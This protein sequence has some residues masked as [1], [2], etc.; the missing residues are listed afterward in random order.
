[1]NK[2]QTL[3]LGLAERFKIVAPG[4]KEEFLDS[5][6]LEEIPPQNPI[7]S[8]MFDVGDITA[9]FGKSK[10]F[11]SWLCAQLAICAATGSDFLN[12]K[13]QKP[14]R[15]CLFQF[16]ISSNHFKRRLQKIVRS[17]FPF[18]EPDLGLMSIRSCR[19]GGIGASEILEIAK[20]DQLE[21]I[22]VDPI[23]LLNEMT[24]ENSA[25]AVKN[26]LKIFG[27]IG[28]LGCAVCYTH[29]DR[30]GST[31]SD[32][33][34]RGSGSGVHARFYDAGIF[35]DAHAE[36]PDLRVIRTVLRNY[37][38]RPDATAE[39]RSGAF[40]LRDDVAPIPATSR[41]RRVRKLDSELIDCVKNSFEMISEDQRV[42]LR[43]LKNDLCRSLNTTECSRALRLLK[44]IPG[45]EVSRIAGCGNLEEVLKK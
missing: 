23:Y 3:D 2:P 43:D 15:T 40:H 27:Q 17:M 6:M 32:L 44:K 16:E 18:E 29:H 10:S 21:F 39:W 33:V 7:I 8:G 26:L 20:K 36:S 9:I 37:P 28:Q 4:I 38:Q 11:K 1:M 30:K 34:D 5:I 42:L 22:C 35:I 31:S 13:I 12:W 14:R 45:F 25:D 19:G 24:E 41:T